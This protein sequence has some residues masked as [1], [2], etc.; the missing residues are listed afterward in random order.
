MDDATSL[1]V[2][3]LAATA[4]VNIGIALLVGSLASLWSLRVLP[5]RWAATKTL[6]IAR[7]CTLAICGSVVAALLLLWVQTALMSDLPLSSAVSAAAPVLAQT[8]FGHAW[9]FGTVALLIA[10]GLTLLRSRNIRSRRYFFGLIV[11]VAFFLAGKSSAGHAGSTDRLLPV[12]VDWLHLLFVGTWSGSVLIAA[13]W[14][15]R[16]APPTGS[17]DQQAC[18]SYVA[19][20][21]R[22]ATWALCGVIATG[23]YSSWR[24]LAGGF[25]AVSSSPYGIAWLVKLSLV[26]LA[27]ALGAVN[28]FVAMPRLLAALR[29]SNGSFDGP[30]HGFGVVL[31]IEALVLLAVLCAAAALSTSAPISPT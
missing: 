26:G 29:S 17:A 21:S 18:A 16:G 27:T 7:V 12:V 3:L 1:G 30:L 11:L 9:T 25:A 8:H 2:A 24:G 22:V 20:L 28:R 14:A 4:L 23:V 13:G 19:A 31:R 15:L 5:S 10:W 6:Q